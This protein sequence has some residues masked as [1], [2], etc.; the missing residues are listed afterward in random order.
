[1][2]RTNIRY[3]DFELIKDDIDFISIDVAFISL[4]LVL[5]VAYNLLKSN[6]TLV[7]LIKPQFEAGREEVG[8]KGVV[9]DIKVHQKVIKEII[10]FSAECGFSV[11]ALDYSPIKGPEGNIEF[12][13]YISKKDNVVVNVNENDIV[14]ITESSRVMDGDSSGKLQ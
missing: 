1:M 6:G 13:L 4:K 3:I 14:D 10:E 11:D 2:E 7:A 8:K 12:L 9:R 5:P